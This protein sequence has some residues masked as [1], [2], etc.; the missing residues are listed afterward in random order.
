MHNTDLNRDVFSLQVEG[1]IQDRKETGWKIRL[2]RINIRKFNTGSIFLYK[3][4]QFTQV[5]LTKQ[6]SLVVNLPRPLPPPLSTAP[7][8]LPFPRT[9]RTSTANTIF[10]FLET[11]L[12][13]VS[14]DVLTCG[15]LSLKCLGRS[16][17]S[18]GGRG[19]AASIVAI[20]RSGRTASASSASELR[21][22]KPARP[23]KQRFCH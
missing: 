17:Y 7:P 20:G 8:A 1:K 10:F 6:T 16:P 18:T 12:S 11:E 21:Q 19:A 5:Y 3:A 13:R 22:L 15:I 9:P 23:A 4:S 14:G 2:N